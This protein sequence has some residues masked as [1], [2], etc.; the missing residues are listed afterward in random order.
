MRTNGSVV[1][2]STPG[3]SVLI[4]SFIAWCAFVF[5]IDYDEQARDLEQLRVADLAIGNLLRRLLRIAQ[6]GIR[7]RIVL[8]HL[9]E[10][11]HDDV[12]LAHKHG[13]QERHPDRPVVG[14]RRR[15]LPR[16]LSEIRG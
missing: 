14:K 11:I 1:V 3:A 9:A 4:W 10:F 8:L 6:A 5:A 12:V 7:V 13:V 15:L 16:S 2:A